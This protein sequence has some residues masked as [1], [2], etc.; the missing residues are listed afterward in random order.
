MEEGFTNYPDEKEVIL[1]DRTKFKIIGSWVLEVYGK[2]VTQIDLFN[3]SRV[4][5]PKRWFD[6]QW[7]VIA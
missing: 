7:D 4:H 1:L 5:K 3:S 6:S 2:R